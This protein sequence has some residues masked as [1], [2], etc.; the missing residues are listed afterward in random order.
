MNLRPPSRADASAATEVIDSDE[1]EDNPQD[2]NRQL[3]IALGCIKMR[4]GVEERN[5]GEITTGQAKRM[6]NTGVNSLTREKR[7][8]LHEYLCTP[9]KLM[10]SLTF[11][12]IVQRM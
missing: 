3:C 5:D 8:G 2:I 11:V 7:C 6:S 9:H 10:C 12:L 4:H 1:V